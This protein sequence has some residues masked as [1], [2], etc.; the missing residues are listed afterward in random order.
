MRRAAYEILSD[1]TFYGEIPGLHGVFANAPTLEG[2]REQLKEVLEGWILLGLRLG[3]KL[4]E[5][6]GI[7]LEINTEVA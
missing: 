7:A 6:D 5:I 1:R 4:P 2:C 3:H